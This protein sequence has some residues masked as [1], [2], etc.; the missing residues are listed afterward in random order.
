M[1]DPRASA[2]PRAPTTEELLP[3][4]M[5]GQRWYAGKGRLPR[6]RRVG[7]FHLEDPAG[8][9]VIE[10]HIVADMSLAP[11]VVYQVPLSYRGGPLPGA[12]HALVASALP[13]EH[14]RRWVYDAPHDPRYAQLL[15][16]LILD[17][18]RSSPPD[19]AGTTD[20]G[21]D[22]HCTG[23]RTDLQ[24]DSSTVLGGE[25][26]NTSVV[27]RMRDASG[28]PAE[29]VIVKVFRVL[30]PGDNPDVVVQAALSAAGSTQVP[31]T[32]GYVGARWGSPA[33]PAGRGA[34]VG[35][36]VAFAQRFFPGVEDAWRV[37]SR[38]VAERTSFAGPARELGA[39]TA[40]IHVQLAQCFGTT[41]ATAAAKSGLLASIRS[42][43]GAALAA[44]PALTAH[45]SVIRS[46][47]AGLARAPW[48]PLQRVHGDYHLGQVLHVGDRGWVAV[49]FEG[50]PLRPLSERVRP[51]LALRDVAGMLRSF[52]Y[53]AGAAEQATP[54]RS[55]R[56]WA[57]ECR[58]AFLEG[59]AGV[60]GRPPGRDA[61]LTRALELDKALYEVVYEARNRPDWLGI[62][63]RAVE[64][65][66]AE[67]SAAP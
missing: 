29:P 2:P 9:V 8:E 15:M 10:T 13:T 50:E 51:D 60:T 64:R 20:R 54:G 62:P 16:R 25:Q 26:S 12:D 4:W 66:A 48:P 30:Q 44:V 6:L 65:L 53:A 27:C 22:G 3:E 43:Y 57:D 32:I 28:S 63:V 46:V 59:Y 42:R 58:M 55:A 39:A 19:R 52:D 24:V 38:A 67:S 31:P 34:T 18:G 61:G 40:R 5:S 45:D 56:G 47:I 21:A 37:A 14:G 36:H 7:G 35:G 33:D 23:P 11:P 1:T 17:G 41:P 49:D